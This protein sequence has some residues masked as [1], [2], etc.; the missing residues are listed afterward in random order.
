MYR[1]QGTA[2]S[3]DLA[4]LVRKAKQRG[5]ILPSPI[6]D[7]RQETAPPLPPG[8]H[9]PSDSASRP[10]Q[11]SSTSSSGYSPP[12]I[13][14]SST[15][16]KGKLQRPPRSAGPSGSADWVLTSPSRYDG[17]SK[18]SIEAYICW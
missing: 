16:P 3:P 15:M 10:R 13:V 1:S 11:R 14:T 2:S 18:A 5:S 6:K 7:R 8:P 17:I 4:T 9:A 12:Q